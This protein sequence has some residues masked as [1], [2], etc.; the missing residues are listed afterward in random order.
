M[1]T[2]EERQ[3]HGRILLLFTVHAANV[4]EL[5]PLTQWSWWH[6]FD[7][8]SHSNH[9]VIIVMC[10]ILTLMGGP[11][12]TGHTPVMVSVIVHHNLRLNTLITVCQPPLTR[13]LFYWLVSVY[14]FSLKSS[15]CWFLGHFKF[16]RFIM[17]WFISFGNE[18]LFVSPFICPYQMRYH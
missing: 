15:F 10:S 7:C 9:V 16:M 3:N 18:Q 6:I 13:C 17:I 1:L 8:V 4:I 14:L 5:F 2:K 11:A 12:N